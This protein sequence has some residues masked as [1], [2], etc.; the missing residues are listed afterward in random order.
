MALGASV[1]QVQGLVMREG[2]ALVVV[3]SVLGLG[4]GL[5]L[6]RALSAF[7]DVLARSFSKGADESLLLIAAPLVLSGLAMLACYLPARRSTRIDPMSALR[8][9]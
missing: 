3:G 2:T 8:E 5:L 1:L 7:S 9:E 6:W 4:G